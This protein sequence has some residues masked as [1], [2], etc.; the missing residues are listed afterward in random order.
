[1]KSVKNRNGFTIVELL[2]SFALTSVVAVFLFNIVFLLKDIYVERSLTGTTTLDYFLF[3]NS[4][5]KDF[6]V[7]NI[8]RI[9]TCSTGTT[10]Y[11]FILN[12]IG[13]TTKRL[14]IND[15]PGDQYVS[16]SRIGSAESY[17]YTLDKYETF[18]N[19]PFGTGY[20]CKKTASAILGERVLSN[21]RGYEMNSYLYI[22][23]PI[24]STVENVNHSI[25]LLYPFNAHAVG[26]TWTYI[27]PN[28][29]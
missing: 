8:K 16:Y 13:V 11:E 14:V 28:C 22:N 4:L 12:D 19:A 3:S 24:V 1:M 21:N 25:K 26:G 23:I 20:A 10:C 27:L 6:Y 9:S 29:P 17:V 15:V 7:D 18:G 5:N 2:T